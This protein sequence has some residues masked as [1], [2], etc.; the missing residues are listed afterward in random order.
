MVISSYLYKE[1]EKK[2]FLKSLFSKKNNYEKYFFKLDIQKKEINFREND[3]SKQV[4]GTIRLTEVTDVI[5]RIAH[6]EGTEPTAF[7]FSVIFGLQPMNFCAESLETKNVWI[8]KIRFVANLPALVDEGPVIIEGLPLKRSSEMP[9]SVQQSF[10]TV[11]T[12]DPPPVHASKKVEEQPESRANGNTNEPTVVAAKPR[13]R[14][15]SITFSYDEIDSNKKTVKEENIDFANPMK[16]RGT[17]QPMYIYVFVNL[18]FAKSKKYFLFRKLAGNN[19]IA[20]ESSSSQS[21]AK[22]RMTTMMGQ[23]GKQAVQFGPSRFRAAAKVSNNEPEA[24]DDPL[25]NDMGISSMYRIY[26]CNR[27][28]K[29][30][31][32]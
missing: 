31:R 5:G 22:K 10:I 26:E 4:L 24:F 30:F 20:G 28:L 18:Y 17:L 15:S 8:Q 21:G 12:E 16:H 29:Y 27:F 3:N 14:R 9:K 1:T 25:E 2:G 6:A 32:C 13:R 19:L 11:I 23:P 7:S